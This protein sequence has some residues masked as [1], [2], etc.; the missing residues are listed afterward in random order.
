MLHSFVGPEGVTSVLHSIC[1]NF[2][3]RVRGFRNPTAQHS[4]DVLLTSNDVKG[5][6]SE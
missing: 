2:R 1:R 4:L 3:G 5:L 6:K